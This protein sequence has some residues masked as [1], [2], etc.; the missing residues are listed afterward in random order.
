MKVELQGHRGARGLFPENTLDGFARTLAFGVDSIELDIAVTAD[1]IPVVSHDPALDPDLT[2]GPDG[3]WLA[4]PGPSIRSLTLSELAR[5]DIGRMRPGSRI[6]GLH[7]E[8]MPQDGARIP[9]LAATLALLAMHPVAVDAEL[10]TLPDRP[11][12]TMAPISMAERVLEIAEGAGAMARLRLRSFHWRALR[13]LRATR[14]DLPLAW[15]TDPRT[16]RAAALWWD[17]MMPEGEGGAGVAAAVAAAHGTDRGPAAI[18]APEHTDLT[19][20]AV[21]AAHGLGL[22][23][24]PWTVNRPEDMRRLVEIGVD[25]FCTD[26]PD[27]G[28]R[29]LDA[30]SR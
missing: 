14:P 8:Q 10:K 23:V 3:A 27:L 29:V 19:A 6:A 16:V 21:A 13:H 22:R 25:G 9:T 18:W 28:R 30:M 20:E 4:A 2:R 17:G 5:Y 15:L 7:P 26:R 1:D 24:M 12:L 11:E